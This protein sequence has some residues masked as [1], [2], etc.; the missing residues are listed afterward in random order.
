[1]KNASERRHDVRRLT[2]AEAA[3]WSGLAVPIEETAS[4]GPVT[5]LFLD[6]TGRPEVRDCLRLMAQERHDLP[7]DIAWYAS[8]TTG[9]GSLFVRI[10]YRSLAPG[11]LVLKFTGREKSAIERLACHGLIT[12]T[13]EPMPEPIITAGWTPPATTFQ[14]C[15]GCILAAADH[16]RTEAQRYVREQTYGRN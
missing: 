6:A 16:L 4:Y 9:C 2:D 13:C 1:M 8:L 10:D 15:R 14:L 12:L 11:E 7:C 5:V 3:E